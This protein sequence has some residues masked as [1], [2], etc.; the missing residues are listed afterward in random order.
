M[1]LKILITDMF[2]IAI[3]M[4]LVILGASK[5]KTAEEI[6]IEDKEQME[7]LKNHNCRRQKDDR[8]NKKK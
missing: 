1:I 7:Y 3:F 8:Q 5:C 4:Y 2:I 6:E